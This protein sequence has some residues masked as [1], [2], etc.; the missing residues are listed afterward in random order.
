[1]LAAVNMQQ[2]SRHRPPWPAPAMRAALF[3]PCYW[4]GLLQRLLDPGV[5]ELDDAL[6]PQLL[7]RVSPLR[8]K[9]VS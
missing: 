9:Y 3:A 5:A 1:M 6:F 2:H 8:S 4:P 7:V